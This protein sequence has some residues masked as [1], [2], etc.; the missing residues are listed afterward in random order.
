MTKTLGFGTE[1]LAFVPSGGRLCLFDVHGWRRIAFDVLRTTVR[2]RAPAIETL[3][4]QVE[5][6][7]A[8]RKGQPDAAERALAAERF[9]ESIRAAQPGEPA[10]AQVVQV[11]AEGLRLW[12]R[13]TDAPA[14]SFFA[15]DYDEAADYGGPVAQWPAYG[16]CQLG[17]LEFPFPGTG[18]QAAFDLFIP[19]EEGVV[20]EP[21]REDEPL[22]LVREFCGASG[23]SA[24]GDSVNL[25][26]EAAVAPAHVGCVP[27]RRLGEGAFATMYFGQTIDSPARVTARLTAARLNAAR[28][29]LALARFTCTESGKGW[30]IFRREGDVVH[31]YHELE[32][33]ESAGVPVMP[34]FLLA[35]AAEGGHAPVARAQMLRVLLETMKG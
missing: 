16:S 19:R 26:V 20:A 4:M 8:A 10:G 1:N 2:M 7:L 22:P 17:D 31:L 33:R 3:E 21:I 24:H 32:G 12:V 5:E 35:A 18:E 11:P 9:I 15:E 30:E 6:R 25:T 34:P 27:L 23:I 13:L 29:A 14:E 28:K